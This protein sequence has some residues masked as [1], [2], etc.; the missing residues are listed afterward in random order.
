MGIAFDLGSFAKH[1][2]GHA[3]GLSLLVTVQRAEVRSSTITP[4]NRVS[5]I[6]TY[7]EAEMA[8]GH[9]WLEVRLREEGAK[10]PSR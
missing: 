1:H 7:H 10:T 3:T 5:P 2:T 9:W 8:R 4:R 6:R